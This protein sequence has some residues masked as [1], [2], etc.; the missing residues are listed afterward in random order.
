VQDLATPTTS[1]PP[2]R[3]LGISLPRQPLARHLLCA[4]V[5]GALLF[6][7]SDNVSQFTDFQLSRIGYYAIALA[8]LTVLTGLNGQLSLGHGAL[9]AVGGYTTAL[10]MKDTTFPVLVDMVVAIAATALAGAVI[11][12][13]AARL[14]GPYLAGATLALAVALPNLAT[15]YS[16]VFGGD[17]GLTINPLTP[18]ASLGANFTPFRWMAWLSILA[19]LITLVLL[20]NLVSSRFG[21]EW[22]AVR[23]DEIA[24]RLAGIHVART[25]IAAFVVSAACAGLAGFFFALT[26][27]LVSPTEFTLLLSLTLLTGIVVGGLGSLVGA[28]WGAIL[29]VYL[30]QWTTDLAKDVHLSGTIGSNLSLAVYG[31]VLIVAMLVFPRGIQ[32]GIQRLLTFLRRRL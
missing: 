22:K 14:R 21:R 29:I 9:I 28:V 32:G 2:G 25:Q 31:V 19:A 23:D 5:A 26:V 1:S 11:G 13:A 30:G 17:Q 10:L 20:A 18:P 16:S 7:L 8:G 24:A 4:V 27:Q 3:R 15:K 12:V 6:L